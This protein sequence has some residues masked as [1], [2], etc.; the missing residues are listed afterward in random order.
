MGGKRAGS[1]RKPKGEI[2]GLSGTP[3]NLRM[4]NDMRAQLDAARADSGRSLTQ[5]VLHRLQESFD[6]D[7]TLDRDR[8]SFWLFYLFGRVIDQVR[9]LTGASQWRSDPFT[10]RATR[11]AF[12]EVLKEIEPKGEIVGPSGALISA[13]IESP[14]RAARLASHMVLKQFESDEF[15]E[16]PFTP[17][18]EPHDVKLA[19]ADARRY[20]AIKQGGSK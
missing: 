14:E 19:M 9:S 13:I 8:A 12:D 15:I 17:G 1:G 6:R 11:L 3:V 4:P 10:F 20:L 2:S 16:E 7:R 18:A 5:E